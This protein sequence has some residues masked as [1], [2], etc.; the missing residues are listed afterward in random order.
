VLGR[1]FTVRGHLEGKP[2]VVREG[3]AMLERALAHYRATHNILR[4]AITTN[5][6][7]DAWEAYFRLTCDEDAH[8]RALRLV[9]DA[10][11]LLEEFPHLRND[12]RRSL[13]EMENETCQTR[14][15]PEKE[16]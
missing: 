12:V 1:V 8:T 2:T 6:L 7:G 11:A 9:E 3:I 5:E 10:L 15:P 16:K 4:S 14:A 13:G